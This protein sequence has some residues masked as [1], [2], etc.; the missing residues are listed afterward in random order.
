MTT[1]LEIEK[2]ERMEAAGAPFGE[3]T[4]IGWQGM[5]CVLPPGW[6]VTGFSLDRD[7]GYLRVDAPGSGMLAVQIRWT[8]A[9][10][11]NP[12]S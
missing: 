9:A 4:V 3:R 10:T 6:N 12:G 1:Q 11:A 8:N 7:S 5:R 2:S